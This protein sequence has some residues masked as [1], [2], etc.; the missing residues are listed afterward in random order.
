LTLAI[1]LASLPAF[2]GLFPAC[3]DQNAIPAGPGDGSGGAQDHGLA[4]AGGG[5]AA[6]GAAGATG[7]G[8]ATGLGGATGGGGATVTIPPPSLVITPQNIDLGVM[9]L[10]QSRETSFTVLNRG[11]FGT[12]APTVQLSAYGVDDFAILSS[13]CDAPLGPGL[14]CAVTIQCQP[15]SVGSKWAL[16]DLAF[17]PGGAVGAG[18]RVEVVAP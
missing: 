6:G 13:T 7:V 16:L 3:R 5:A 11:A 4:G 12:G 2:G 10:G 18:L 17:V 8:G 15:K 14:T 1:T 9:T